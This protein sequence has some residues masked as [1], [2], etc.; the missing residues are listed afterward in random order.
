MRVEEGKLLGDFRLIKDMG[1]SVIGRTVLAEHRFTRQKVLLKILSEDLTADRTFISRFEEESM[2]LSS[3]DHPNIAKVYTVSFIDGVY[4]L[5][6][7]SVLN[8]QQEIVTVHDY[9][10]SHQCTA[11]EALRIGEQ[12][13]QALD[14]AHTFKTIGILGKAHSFSHGNIYPGSI[15]LSSSFE[16]GFDRST[17]FIKLADFGLSRIIGQSTWLVKSL[18]SLFDEIGDSKN[19]VVDPGSIARA[20]QGFLFLSPEQKRG[21]WSTPHE[22]DIW[23]FGVLLYWIATGGKYP[24]G[25]WAPPQNGSKNESELLLS[26]IQRCLQLNP[27]DRPKLLTSLFQETLRQKESSPLDFLQ[28]ISSLPE[29][30]VEVEH[31]LSHVEKSVELLIA[32]SQP[33]AKMVIQKSLSVSEPSIHDRKTQSI[34][35]Y[36]P[37]KR[38]TQDIHPLYTNMVLISQGTYDRGSNQ[39]CRDELPRHAIRLNQF[40]IDMHPVTNEQFVRFLEFVGDEKDRN[41]QDIIRL[42]D[43]RIK[44]SSG[45]FV[46][47]RGYTKHP[48]VG[49]TWY[50]A[51]AYATWIGKRLPTEA[52][53]EIACCGGLDNPTYPTGETI[54]RSQA[55]FF[56]SDTT[57]VMSYPGNEYEL[58]DMVGNVYEWCQDWYEYSYY[59]F[60]VMEP[61]NPKGPIQGVYRVLRGGCWKS[62]KEDLRCAKR[63]RNNPGAANRTYGFRCAADIEE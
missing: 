27:Q 46:I 2:V 38:D 39:G 55:N 63:H 8:E 20:S 17:P 9:I 28:G 40:Q 29:K 26:V 61:D 21:D 62:L 25:A 34:K 52:E 44:K 60:S 51:S 36:I 3:L 24:E 16:K 43:S 58:Y 32:S 6:A 57:P 33:D 48:V 5:V 42:R 23:S 31:L 10:K 59:D 22:S 37:E 15:F 56:S 41:N 11:S 13:A 19:S 53:W 35:E 50:G 45:A 4:I 18:K 30:S 47:E 54:E 7:E 1:Q 14:Y 49:V 12:I